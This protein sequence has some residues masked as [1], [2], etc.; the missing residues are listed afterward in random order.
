MS[1]PGEKTPNPQLPRRT[2][3]GQPCPRDH[4]RTRAEKRKAGNRESRKCGRRA[5][6]A[7]DRGKEEKMRREKVARFHSPAESL[8]YPL[9]PKPSTP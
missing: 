4:G 7:W 8:N 9:N 3:R 6:A 1:G 5:G 2:E